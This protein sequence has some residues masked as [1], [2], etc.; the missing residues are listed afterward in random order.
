MGVLAPVWRGWLAKN[1]M[2]VRWNAAEGCDVFPNG[3][4]VYLRGVLSTDATRRYSKLAGLTLAKWLLDEAHEVPGDVIS[5]FWPAR[6][7][8]PGFPHQMLFLA[9]PGARGLV[10]VAAVS[11]QGAAD[12]PGG[13][14]GVGARERGGAGGG[15]YPDARG[16][17]SAGLGAAPA[18]GAWGGAGWGTWARRCL[19]GCSGGTSTWWTRC[20]NPDVALV[21]GFDWGHKHPAAVWLQFT[22]Q[23]QIVVLGGVLGTDLFIEDFLPAVA[24]WEA[25]WFPDAQQRWYTGDPAGDAKASQGQRQSASR[26]GA[27]LWVQ[28]ADGGRGEPAG[29]AEPG[30]SG[31]GAGDAAADGGGAGVR[32]GPGRWVEL[33]PGARVVQRS[34]VYIDALEAGLVWD[35][36]NYHLGQSGNVRRVQK[37]GASGRVHAPVRRDDLRG[38]AVRAGG[39][40]GGGCGPRAGAGRAPGAAGRPGPPAD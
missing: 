23:G 15:V 30:D 5:A 28:R 11:A 17:V 2:E 26:S 40:V 36:R 34:E 22:P 13:H 8:Q 31:D 14:H 6:L 25:E 27:G 16:A 35:E 12:G 1:G 18:A 39:D 19:A 10:A 4:R 33:G 7:S 20:V 3:S 29:G 9:N 38:V 32:G 21:C 24:R 37:D